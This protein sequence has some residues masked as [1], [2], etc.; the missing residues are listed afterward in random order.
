[1]N[2]FEAH[3]IDH[4]SPS[5]LN[6]WAMQPALWVME[7]LLGIRAPVS[8]AAHRGTA[9]E[10]GVTLGL[11]NPDMS[12][13]ECKRE[14]LLR[15][16]ELAAFSGD[17]RKQKHREEVPGMVENALLELRQ[18]GVPDR[19]QEKVS[20]LLPGLPVPVIGYLDFAWISQHGIVADLKT[21]ERLPSAIADAHARQGAL[22]VHRSNYEMRFAY[23][24][25]KSTTPKVAVYVLLD[26][27]R[28]MRDLIVI[29]RRL[30]RFLSLS[31]DPHE[32]AGLLCPNL[33]HFVFND[34]TTRANARQ[35]FGFEAETTGGLDTQTAG[36]LIEG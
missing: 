12:V 15:F 5:S 13:S 6:A 27:Q 34:P 22:Y 16:D 24:T 19:V 14:A 29:G 7:R 33:E 23:I 25:A 20:H 8:C 10:Q 18:Y 36:A 21:S 3:G 11:V 26:A 31:R 17:P 28:H 2:T 30:E 32:L 35:C 4:L 9:V 1:V